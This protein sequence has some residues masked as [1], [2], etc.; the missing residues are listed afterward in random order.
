MYILYI[1]IHTRPDRWIFSQ[2]FV[3]FNFYLGWL[4][5]VFT[6]ELFLAWF[7]LRFTQQNPPGLRSNR[8]LLLPS[9]FRWCQENWNLRDALRK[10][11]AKTIEWKAFGFPGILAGSKL[12]SYVVVQLCKICRFGGKL[13]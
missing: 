3:Q 11:E 6:T 13:R 5:I 2:I 8:L 10:V 7:E 9:P 1:Y 12:L 4:C